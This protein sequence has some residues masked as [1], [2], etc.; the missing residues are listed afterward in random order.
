MVHIV[1]RLRVPLLAGMAL[2]LPGLLSATAIGT[3]DITGVGPVRLTASTIDFSPVG[4]GVG[5]FAVVAGTGDFS[6]LSL[7]S[8]GTIADLSDPPV[9]AGP[10]L[11]VPVSPFMIVPSPGTI[12]AFNL[13]QILLGGG[14]PCTPLP[15]V[16]DSCT[17]SEL[18]PNSPFLLTQFADSVGLAFSV[19]G[20]VSDNRD[21]TSAGYVG[22]FTANLTSTDVN[23]VSEVLAALG[24]GGPGFVQ[25]SWS[26]SFTSTAIPEPATLALIGGGLVVLVGVGRRRKSRPTA[27]GSCYRPPNRIKIPQV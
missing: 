3:L 16:N 21:F 18:W 6:V 24:P 15:G 22:L 10:L 2:M 14:P 7:L 12:F 25:S 1:G 9:T 20:T 8:I 27:R 4:G 5:D 19:R 26:A 17:P 23:T 11:A 13:E